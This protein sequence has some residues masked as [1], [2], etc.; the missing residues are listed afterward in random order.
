M[1]FKIDYGIFTESKDAVR[2][3]KNGINGRFFKGPE[4]LLIPISSE[5]KTEL[6][7]VRRTRFNLETIANQVGVIYAVKGNPRDPYEEFKTTMKTSFTNDLLFPGVVPLDGA[8]DFLMSI[9]I[10]E[11]TSP[12]T[13]WSSDI[14]KIKGDRYFLELLKFESNYNW[15]PQEFGRFGSYRG[16]TAKSA[17]R[18]DIIYHVI[19]GV[20][21]SKEAELRR[22]HY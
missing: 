7:V 19:L 17:K 6:A 4:S 22:E 16:Y 11:I 5:D 20:R 1:L 14:P 21:D 8:E 3:I 18:E 13:Y 12:F 15:N 2:Q 10:G 9:A